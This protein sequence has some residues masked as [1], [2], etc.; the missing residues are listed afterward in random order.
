[1]SKTLAMLFMLFVAASIAAQ[2]AGTTNQAP[3]APAIQQ[4]LDDLKARMDAEHE[5]I[6]QLQRQLLDREQG[7]Q[8]LQQEMNGLQDSTLQTGGD[9]AKVDTQTAY[10]RAAVPAVADIVDPEKPVS[11][12]FRGVTLT[13]GGFFDATGIYRTHNE[14]ADVDSTFAGIPFSGTAN[15]HL[16]EFRGSARASRFSLLAEGKFNNWK[17][18]WGPHFST[19][20]ASAS[21]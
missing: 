2:E 1:M 10:P 5:R 13:P 4:Q 21:F 3:I 19:A 8:Q 17:R 7:L 11:I 14:N 16:S 20:W 12:R 15:A 18:S 9:A 6:Q